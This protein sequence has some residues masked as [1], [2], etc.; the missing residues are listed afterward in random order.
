MAATKWR[1]LIKKQCH[2]LLRGSSTRLL[3]TVRSL[4]SNLL[5][6]ELYQH[7]GDA[8]D[9]TSPALSCTGREVISLFVFFPQFGRQDDKWRFAQHFKYG[10]YKRLFV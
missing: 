8:F 4:V 7:K 5:H 3:V 2:H 6:D 9:L 10:F 1:F